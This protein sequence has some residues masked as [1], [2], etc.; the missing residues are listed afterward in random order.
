LS[1]EESANGEARMTFT[2]HLGELRTRL[3]RSVL[4]VAVTFVFCAF[5]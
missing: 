2:E 3:I 4:S 5:F 1:E